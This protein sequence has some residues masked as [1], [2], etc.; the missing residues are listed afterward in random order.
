MTNE[1]ASYIAGAIDGEGHISLIPN[2]THREGHKTPSFVFC[3]AITNTN[4]S[5][6]ETLSGWI[7]GGIIDSLIS[8]AN[9]RPCYRL[10]FRGAEGR[11]LLLRVMPFLLMK[12]ERA[13]LILQYFELAA[14]RRA[15]NLPGTPSDP[16]IVQRLVAIHAELK[17]LNQRG[18]VN[19]NTGGGQVSDRKCALDGCGVKHYSSGYCRKHYRRYCEN[20][21]FKVYERNCINCGRPFV[22]RRSDTECCSKPCTDRHQYVKNK[23]ARNAYKREW[24]EKQKHKSRESA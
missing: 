18:I 14:R 3:I 11:T 16:E 21:G 12:K 15:S 10:R 4:H 19:T 2:G 9:K 13:E 1:Q 22:A 24:R 23:E 7:G 20:G 5:W 6:L 8:K 17:R